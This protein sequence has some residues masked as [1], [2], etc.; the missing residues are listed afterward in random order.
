MNTHYQSLRDSLA[1]R[2]QD[3]GDIP[4]AE[5]R[6]LQQA[7][8]DHEFDGDVNPWIFS[9]LD[10]EHSARAGEALQMILEMRQHEMEV[11]KMML[12]TPVTVQGISD[13]GGKL[14][15]LMSRRV[16]LWLDLENILLNHLDNLCERDWARNYTGI[17]ISQAI[18]EF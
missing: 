2:Y 8:Y 1:A 17:P 6:E 18:P 7:M 16:M 13:W 10:R 12:D 9:D 3:Y 11:M 14:T 5:L 4:A 15:T